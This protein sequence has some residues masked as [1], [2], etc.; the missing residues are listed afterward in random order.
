MKKLATVFVLLILS[1]CL[2]ACNSKVKECEQ[3]IENI[4][5]LDTN[6]SFESRSGRFQID[7]VGMA[8]F[9]EADEFY[10]NLSSNQQEKV[11][12][13][14]KLESQRAAYQELEEAYSL[15]KIK[16]DIWHQVH[17]EVSY[18]AKRMLKTPSSFEE[19]SF[20]CFIYEDN[21][22]LNTGEFH[23]L[24]WLNYSGTN[25]FGGRVDV[26]GRFE[27]SG[28]YNFDTTSIENL[29]VKSW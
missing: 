2:T 12:N 10:G 13:V 25:S 4:G 9:E 14:D 7:S 1:V 29:T 28:T 18:K 11:K 23:L 26:T 8:R 19:I 20:D 17:D 27:V 3:L 22:D 6:Y 24:P 15:L 5:R 21:F 16:A